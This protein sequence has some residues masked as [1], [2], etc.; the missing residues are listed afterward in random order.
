MP[1][2]LLGAA[3]G[4]TGSSW[5]SWT[6][7]G[8]RRAL[9]R[10]LP[11][12]RRCGWSRAPRL[13]IDACQQQA[14]RRRVTL[15]ILGVFVAVCGAFLVLCAYAC[16]FMRRSVD[17]GLTVAY[18]WILGVTVLAWV[19]VWVYLK[20]VQC[21]APHRSDLCRGGVGRLPR[22]LALA[23]VAP[24]QQRR[25]RIRNRCGVVSSIVLIILSPQ[26]WSPKSAAP[27]PLGNPAIVS[28]PIGFLG[29]LIGTLLGG[30]DQAALGR[31]DEVRVRAAT[32]LGAE[33]GSPRR[34][35]ARAEPLGAG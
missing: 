23:H 2:A 5:L 28:V 19:L 11:G 1:R 3:A 27:F 20:E 15:T 29:C 25:R 6:S 32:G 4:R 31:F 12:G 16:S 10:E 17:G 18:V 22:A 14:L 34:S 26:V 24:V 13:S 33:A 21:P 35:R 9:A 7:C 8:A 30:R